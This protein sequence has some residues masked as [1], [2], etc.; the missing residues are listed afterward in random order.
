M[1]DK[2]FNFPDD[3]SDIESV[4]LHNYEE[5]NKFINFFGKVKNLLLKYKDVHIIEINFSRI[6][7]ETSEILPFTYIIM[8]NSKEYLI[9]LKNESKPS[10]T[11]EEHSDYKNLFTNNPSQV[12]IIIVWN[13]SDLIS[14]KLYRG[15]IYNPYEGLM[16]ILNSKDRLLP[17]EKLI[18]REIGFRDKFSKVIVPPTSDDIKV[19][20][21]PNLEKELYSNVKDSYNFYKTR[22]FKEPKRSIMG[23]IKF[24]DF[25]PIF[26]LVEKFITQGIE[27]EEIDEI[28]K[29]FKLTEE[30][31]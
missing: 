20:S 28:I 6:I 30:E 16:E 5:M 27:I 13:N 2:D 25:E 10:L 12:G 22:K 19:I 18:N 14:L 1:E 29:L 15:E 11:K 23:N 24:E 7:P 4:F 3:I 21:I 8:I 26:S 17:L 31:K 9:F